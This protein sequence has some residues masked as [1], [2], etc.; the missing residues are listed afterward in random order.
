MKLHLPVTL[1]RAVMALFASQV[2]LTSAW[3]EETQTTTPYTVESD[4]T[5]GSGEGK[6]PW[7]GKESTDRLENVG[8][9]TFTSDP[10]KVYS[11]TF[12]GKDGAFDGE[13]DAG[14]T[15]IVGNTVTF[16]NL[17]GITFTGFE[18]ASYAVHSE[19]LSFENNSNVSIVDNYKTVER[20]IGESRIDKSNIFAGSVTLSGNNEI[21]MSRN[22]VESGVYRG[23]GEELEY[24][25]S[26][27]GGVIYNSSSLSGAD[28]PEVVSVCGNG[29]VEFAENKLVSV[30]WEAYGAAVYSEGRVVL[31]DN[32]KVVFAGNSVDSSYGDNEDWSSRNPYHSE[33]LGGAI[34]SWFSPSEGDEAKAGVS[35]VGNGEVEFSEN[36]AVAVMDASGGAIH[37]ESSETQLSGNGS[38]TFRDNKVES[39]QDEYPKGGSVV[40]A[41]GGA[42]YSAKKLSITGNGNILFDGNTVSTVGA[43]ARGSAIAVGHNI[44]DLDGGV[45][46]D[47]NKGTITLSN[48]G[49]STYGKYYGKDGNCYSGSSMAAGAVLSLS[50]LSMSGNVGVITFSG[51]YIKD[52]A[53]TPDVLFGF[54]GN[55]SKEQSGL[56]AGAA[57][58]AIGPM[59]FN[60]NKSAIIFDSNTIDAECK[61]VFGGAMVNVMGDITFNLNEG[62]IAFINN[63]ASTTA[64]G[65]AWGGAVSTCGSLASIL[66]PGAV[67]ESSVVFDGNKDISFSGNSVSAQSGMANGGAIY[68]SND[69]TMVNNGD[70]SFGG[71]IQE[72]DAVVAQEQEPAQNAAGNTAQGYYANGG[73]IYSEGDVTLGYVDGDVADYG[74]GSVEFIGNSALSGDAHASGGAIFAGGNVTVS[75]NDGLVKFN[76]NKVQSGGSTVEGSAITAAG[77]VDISGNE[78]GVEIKDNSAEGYGNAMGAVYAANAINVQNNGGVTIEGNSATEKSNETGIF[79]AASGGGLNAGQVLNVSGN[80]AVV[81]EGNS[82][83]SA[84]GYAVAGGVGAFEVSLS[85][86][87][88]LT[89]VENAATGSQYAGGGAILS[90]GI[91]AISGQDGE[92]SFF[93]NKAI[94]QDETAYGG[95]VVA[96]I[97]PGLDALRAQPDADEGVIGELAQTVNSVAISD[98]GAV[99]FGKYIEKDGEKQALGNSAIGK[100]AHGGAIYSKGG[101]TL[102]YVDEN[103]EKHGNASVEF[104][105]NEAKATEGAAVGGAIAAQGAV[106]LDNN[107]SVTFSDNKASSES[108]YA[109][110]GAISSSRGGVS[111]SGNEA[112]TFSGNSAIAQTN[113]SGG[114]IYSTKQDGQDAYVEIL[115]N[116]GAVT[117]ENN[118][119]IASIHASRGGAICTY[120]TGVVI[121]GNTYGVGTELPA[122]EEDIQ[123]SLAFTGNIAAS[124]QNSQAV[125]GAIYS[126]GSV[127]ITGNGN[128]LFRDN[129]VS[130]VGGD[131]F[132]AAIGADQGGLFIDDNL[133]SLT[134]E[135]NKVYAAGTIYNSDGSYYWQGASLVSGAVTS[136]TKLSISRNAGDIVFSGNSIQE[137]SVTLKEGQTLAGSGSDS[138]TIS[139]TAG[140]AV[141]AM[142][143]V[144]LDGNQGNISFIGNT[145]TSSCKDVL[146][147]AI[148]SATGDIR[149]S[150]NNKD[151]AVVFS[152]NSVT[153]TKSSAK[154]GAIGTYAYNP[155]SGSSASVVIA[156]NGSITFSDN[157]V[158]AGVRDQDGNIVSYHNSARGGAIYSEGDVELSH[159]GAV[160]FGGVILDEDGETVGY[161]NGNIVQGGEAHGGAIYSVGN[162]TLSNNS[163]VSFY[164]NALKPAGLKAF[165]GAVY[166]SGAVSI[167]NN[168]NGV[169][170]SGNTITCV[171]SGDGFGGAIYAGL[172]S[173]SSYDNAD[174]GHN[175]KLSDNGNVTFA[176]NKIESEFRARG[177]AIYADGHITLSDNDKVTFTGNSVVSD[178]GG[179]AI[180]GAISTY[181]IKSG[182]NKIEIF[183]KIPVSVTL[184]GNGDINFSGN[185]ATAKR[186]T[187]NG[188]AI[189]SAGQINITGNKGNITFSENTATAESAYAACGGALA[190]FNGVNIT[191]NG[192][193]NG[194]KVTIEFSE[195]TVASNGGF[196]GAAGIYSYCEDVVI[197]DNNADIKF[198]GNTVSGIGRYDV[199]NEDE[200]TYK[201]DFSQVV[202]GGAAIGTDYS[203]VSITR[204]GDVSF[205][206]NAAIDKDGTQ[207]I[208]VE[209]FDE[210]GSDMVFSQTG[211]GAIMAMQNVNIDSNEDVTIKGNYASSESRLTTG[212]AIVALGTVSLS[213]N[214]GD[215]NVSGNYAASKTGTAIGGAIFAGNGLSIVNNGDVTFSGNYTKNGD[216]YQLNSVYVQDG[217]VELAAA[218][219]KSILFEDSFIVAGGDNPVKLNSYTDAEGNTQTSTGAIVFSGANAVETLQQLKG[220]GGKVS[221]GEI[222]ASLT[223]Q[224]NRDVTVAGGSL[225]VKDG[226]VLYMKE[227]SKNS[228]RVLSGAEL[229]IGA[230]STVAVGSTVT[231]E[232]GSEFT[233]V[234]GL[235]AAA[236]MSVAE[237]ASSTPAAAQIVGNV[238]LAAGMTYTMDGA[239]ANLLGDD[240]T[241]TLDSAGGYTFNVD[242]SLAST[243]GNTKY[244]V[245]FTGIEHLAGVDL[246]ALTDIEFTIGGNDGYYT[247]LMLNYIEGTEAG[248]VLYISATV[249]EPTTA[250]LSLLALATLA[251]RRRRR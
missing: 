225:Q 125:G 79:T 34:F 30:G 199:V 229:L 234:K 171:G 2:A 181:L 28:T 101:V 150:N 55:A 186:A 78:A 14:Y 27:R 188:G 13:T 242:E 191:G 133:G 104:I 165:G 218:K 119:A 68:S 131:V 110:G 205:T 44:P 153:S 157:S 246:S 11:V 189:Y 232:S 163:S 56:A 51:N 118:H 38:L 63:S 155:N 71:G 167:E 149:I 236:T 29:Y 175:V 45:F 109:D 151:K 61:S 173:G 102:G 108:Q 94:S 88:S 176:D 194:E 145:I 19:F 126:I 243:K 33:A 208:P 152:G 43:I 103:G 26:L 23:N 25:V 195:N 227:S 200:T 22:E 69:V 132:G 209:M 16:E 179:S 217:N 238:E 8:N 244:F 144:N 211:G 32:A 4:V 6:T 196:V 187:T 35:F 65:Y 120:A 124:L 49:V 146:G 228:L 230:G 40:I 235:E 207:P 239:Y 136:M 20:V 174:F 113:T 12:D 47:E 241:L 54:N 75:G 250:T 204:N 180:G 147:G 24:G 87:E 206:G 233:T 15:A 137:K 52:L 64:L 162:V 18:G 231:F 39:L 5:Y 36:S 156:D 41:E 67:A 86:N 222:S 214:K 203:S 251:A 89:F 213:H 59:A 73:A 83:S 139:I 95:A 143:N 3:A 85:G 248:G 183:Q 58:V 72:E 31:E 168:T 100:H 121:S 115:N 193:A 197:S 81:V 224:I 220:E 77:N 215:V 107:G 21:I 129:I 172:N 202:V 148:A 46:I 122:G 92:V 240:N 112:V 66:S 114:A 166:S 57:I 192:V 128:V 223:S 53:G 184:S 185:S 96:D 60:G 84:N 177:G 216:M 134:V 158:V 160:S 142:S 90:T 123:Y 127:S 159:N 201:E 105:G 141:G 50:S 37:N 182:D 169:N 17:K 212:G 161:E 190:G 42:I 99:S 70:I 219:D 117:F 170:F 226:A 62:N 154:G 135:G 249:P 111:I 106:A 237:T 82:V 76:E 80:G 138:N 116:T 7:E 98:N 178:D 221:D 247:D 1:L 97:T 140:A 245:L 210:P 164:G 130:S 48:N 91:L 74:N 10:E 93:G 9:V 198:S